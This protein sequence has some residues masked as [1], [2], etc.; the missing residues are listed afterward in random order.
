[1]QP[2]W[3][4]IILT[5]KSPRWLCWQSWY[6]VPMDQTSSNLKGA[7]ERQAWWSHGRFPPQWWGK[8]LKSRTSSNK[9]PRLL[10][11]WQTNS[12][13]GWHA[14]Y[15]R[16]IEHSS[17]K[18][19]SFKLQ[20]SL[21]CVPPSPDPIA[22]VRTGIQTSHRDRT[23]F[24]LFFWISL[25]NPPI[26]PPNISC[27]CSKYAWVVSRHP[28]DETRITRDRGSKD[29]GIGD[30]RSLLLHGLLPFTILSRRSPLRF[31]DCMTGEWR[32]WSHRIA[33]FFPYEHLFMRQ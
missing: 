2:L 11:K 32:L 22:L 19:K 8:R 25:G 15:Q 14:C 16:H 30:P 28:A 18:S 4:K 9:Q 20:E 6:L 27:V 23:I 17:C 29:P 26:N 33:S 3:N 1:M 5:S 21:P 31:G 13:D 24:S 10:K 12:E 7:G